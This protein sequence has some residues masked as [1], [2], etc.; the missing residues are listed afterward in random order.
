[1]D[2]GF[3]TT[4]PSGSFGSGVLL[5]DEDFDLPPAPPPLAE[6]EIVEP[7]FSAFEVE[8]ARE[9]ALLKGRDAALA[10][11]DASDRAAARRALTVISGQIEAARADVSAIAEQSAEAMARL[12]LDC[13]ATAFPAL[14][15][16]HGHAEIA[17]VLHRILPALHQEPRITIRLNP[18]IVEAMTEE[19]GSLDPDLR[20][21]VRL[22]PT[23]AVTRDDVRIDWHNGSATRDTNA[24]WSQ[25]ET[26]LAPAGL[27][28][29]SG[30]LNTEPTAKEHELVI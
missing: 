25:I 1:M 20:A 19:I 22:V 24:L 2:D 23:D 28:T 26:I 8:T 7:V 27:L 18:H 9:A 12:L 13:F 15:A 16:R 21:H 30:S 5:F 4:S 6:P 14:S 29:T 11:A 10:E 17:A 3:F